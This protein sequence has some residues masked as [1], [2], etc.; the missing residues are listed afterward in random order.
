MFKTIINRL[1]EPSTWAGLSALG[2]LF[3]LSPEVT[4]TAGTMV[5]HAAEA[6]TAGAALVA[7]FKREGGHD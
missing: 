7:I 6:I 2:L 1:R 3:G 4:A 5:G